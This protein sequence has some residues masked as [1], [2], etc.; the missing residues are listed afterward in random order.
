MKKIAL[1]VVAL[2]TLAL[3][4]AP[5]SYNTC[6]ACHGL[7]GEKNTIAKDL[8][9]SSLTKAEVEKALHGYKDGSYGGPMKGIM[10][11]QVMRLTD[12]DIKE[13]SEYIGK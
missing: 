11:G 8:I 3:A 2:A 13:L 4:D 1:T 9:P 6:K 10:K 7:Q 12:A 5:V